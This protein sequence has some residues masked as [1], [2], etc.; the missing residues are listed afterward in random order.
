MDEYGVKVPNQKELFRFV[1]ELAFK[2][3]RLEKEVGRLKNAL[4]LRNKKAVTECLAQPSQQP[5]RL[6]V[7]WWRSIH[8]SETHLQRVFTHNLTEGIKACIE[9]HLAEHGASKLPV[10]SFV[11]KPKNVYVYVT[12]ENGADREWRLATSTDMENMVA[13]LSQ[14]FLREFIVWRKENAH[15]FDG[16]EMSQRD[17]LAYMMKTNGMDLSLDK[18]AGEIKHWLASQIQ[19]SIRTVDFDF[20]E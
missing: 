14:M 13:Q 3:D 4:S 5:N 1:Q 16:S 11:E 8:I 19:E 7:D 18:R 10:R 2:C 17:E 6:F 9:T 20:D 15:I 12:N